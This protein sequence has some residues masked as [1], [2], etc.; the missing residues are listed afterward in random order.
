MK[1]TVFAN[2]DPDAK[3]WVAT[4]DDVPGLATEAPTTEML[5]SK[6]ELMIPELLELNNNPENEGS[7]VPVTFKY[8]EQRFLRIA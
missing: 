3:V 4:S 1:I 6:V 8:E 5:V 7:I 2:W